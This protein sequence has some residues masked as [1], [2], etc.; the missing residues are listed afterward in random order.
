MKQALR[1]LSL[2]VVISAAS[3]LLFSGTA[4]AFTSNRVIDDLIYD[5]TTSMSPTQ[6]NSFLN[7][8]S[9]SCI[10]PNNGFTAPD[11]TGYSP[12]GGF[13][14]GGNTTAGI[15][16][17]HAAETYGI[18]PQVLLATLQKEQNLV[19]GGSGCSTLRY[20]AAVGYGC[21]DG[22]TTYSYSGVDLY[23][24]NG[25]TV[26][27]VSGTCVNSSAKVGFSQQVIRAAWLLK[28]GEQ[29]SEG[30]VNWAVIETTSS[31][32]WGNHWVSNWNNSD[33]PQSCYS[34][35]MTQGNRQ[36]CPNSPTAYYDGYTTI[37]GVSTH[38]DTGST[39]ALYWYT[40]HFSGNQSFQ[41]IFQ[42][43]F[44]PTTTSGFTWQYLGQNAYTDQT[45]STV[46]DLTNV[47]AGTRV[48]LTVQVKNT[49]TQTW[50]QGI[51]NLATSEPQN[52]SSQFYDSSWPTADRAATLDQASVAPG[53]TGSFS[54]W[55]TAPQTAGTYKEYFTPVADNITWFTDY[56]LY[57]QIT[58]H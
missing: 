43:W 40:P 7:G 17:D 35:P 8:F 22:G 6:I 48:Y 45:K 4:L 3:M 29:R 32:I 51:V 56:G 19:T 55:V 50:T 12:S 53:Q 23:T 44:G 54:F 18:N 58:V 33:D 24:I 39:A 41:N 25:N 11:Y 28:F 2:S 26:T 52:R 31:D 21:P 27:S 5:N 34:G 49:G 37:D 47:V 15:I 20:A 38:M 42:N 46:A 16:I 30:N 57:W 1:F 9:G 36:T 13:T 14:Y 10:S